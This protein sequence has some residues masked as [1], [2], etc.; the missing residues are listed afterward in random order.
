M[1][2]VFDVSRGLKSS[3]FNFVQFANIYDMSV[4]LHV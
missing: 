1:Y 3:V 4:T 2:I